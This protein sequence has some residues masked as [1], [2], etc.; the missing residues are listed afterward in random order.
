MGLFE[1][2]RVILCVIEAIFDLALVLGKFFIELDLGLDDLLQFNELISLLAL[3]LTF[4]ILI[5]IRQMQKLSMS[6]ANLRYSP[7]DY[8]LK[9]LQEQSFLRVKQ[10]D[11]I[12]FVNLNDDPGVGWKWFLLW[13]VED[14]DVPYGIC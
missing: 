5:K 10:K 4:P 2:G 13:L 1:D 11:I 8:I 6:I 3:Y 7:H 12:L 9:T 14:I